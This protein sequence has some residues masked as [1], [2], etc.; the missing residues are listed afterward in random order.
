M[1]RHPMHTINPHHRHRHLQ[2]VEILLHLPIHIVTI[3]QT[4][5]VDRPT[6][7][8]TIQNLHMS[9]ITKKPTKSM[10]IP[11]RIDRLRTIRNGEGVPMKRKRIRC[12]IVKVRFGLLACVVLQ[13]ERLYIIKTCRHFTIEIYNSIIRNHSKFPVSFQKIIRQ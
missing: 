12:E 10:E 2:I 11:Y 6:P 3:H 9:A 13:F 1:I 7:I 4:L 8:S 5:I